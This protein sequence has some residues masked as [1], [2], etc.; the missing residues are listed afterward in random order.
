MQWGSGTKAAVSDG[1]MYGTST[2]IYVHVKREICVSAR[3]DLCL[4]PF[5]FLLSL[6]QRGSLYLVLR[7]THSSIVYNIWYQSSSYLIRC[8][9]VLVSS[10]I[11][12]YVLHAVL[13]H[14]T[15]TIPTLISSSSVN[16][17]SFSSPGGTRLQ[18]RTKLV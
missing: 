8:A 13:P 1:V 18:F 12:N 9:C 17:S 4:L 5:S 7:G 2:T 15:T 10:I 6:L 14:G 3:R 16:L 11:Q